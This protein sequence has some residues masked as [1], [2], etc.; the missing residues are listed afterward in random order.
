MR[1]ALCQRFYVL[2]P[3]SLRGYTWNG[4][5]LPA[6]RHYGVET[7]VFNQAVRRNQNRFPE[8]FMFPALLGGDGIFKITN[9]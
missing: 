6:P 2:L 8:D 5:R 1:F 3:F 4:E 9:L 7:R